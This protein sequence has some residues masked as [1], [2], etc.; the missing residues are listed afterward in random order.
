MNKAKAAFKRIWLELLMLAII[1]L[2]LFLLPVRIERQ[3]LEVLLYKV[4]LFSASQVH[5]HATR[6]FFFP[7]IDFRTSEEKVHQIMVIALHVMAAYLYA[8]GG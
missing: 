6:K 4:M 5:A 1:G 2:V 3:G 8:E 7:Y